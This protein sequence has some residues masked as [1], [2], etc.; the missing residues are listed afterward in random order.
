M[1][2]PVSIKVIVVP[3]SLNTILCIS[4]GFMQY[5]TP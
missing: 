1:G 4:S 5:V 3:Q 2:L